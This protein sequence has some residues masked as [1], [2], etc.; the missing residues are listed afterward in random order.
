MKQFSFSVFRDSHS[1]PKDTKN[2]HFLLRH[3]TLSA[4]VFSLSSGNQACR[5]A[6]ILLIS[7]VNKHFS[8]MLRL[9]GFSTRLHFISV[10][11]SCHLLIYGNVQ[12]IT[13]RALKSH[14]RCFMLL[15]RESAKA[16]AWGTRE[17]RKL[18]SFS[19]FQL[20][21]IFMFHAVRKMKTFPSISACVKLLSGISSSTKNLALLTRCLHFCNL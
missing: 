7:K 4:L 17:K 14:R 5:F 21:L 3:R 8:I 9:F 10:L 12:L 15:P 20:R 1:T 11:M 19:L 13:G 16:M 2:C 6:S 18:K